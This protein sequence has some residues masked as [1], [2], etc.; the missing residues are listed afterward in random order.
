M[1]K[2][3]TYVHSAHACSTLL[4]C[5]VLSRASW[6]LFL[7]SQQGIITTK[8]EFFFSTYTPNNAPTHVTI[9]NDEK[10]EA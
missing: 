10:P 1:L 9:H 5:D 4:R 8:K 6:S 2:S 3:M 7:I